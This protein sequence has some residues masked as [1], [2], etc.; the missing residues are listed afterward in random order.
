MVI[1]ILLCWLLVCKCILSLGLWRESNSIWFPCIEENQFLSA[2]FPSLHVA[3]NRWYMAGTWYNWMKMIGWGVILQQSM[4]ESLK[5]ERLVKDPSVCLCVLGEGFTVYL[6]GVCH[7]IFQDKR[8]W[9]QLLRSWWPAV[10]C[11]PRDLFGCSPVFQTLEL[12]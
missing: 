11:W 12:R 4:I 5:C 10:T 8:L 3:C 1:Q 2:F 7:L 6:C 9:V